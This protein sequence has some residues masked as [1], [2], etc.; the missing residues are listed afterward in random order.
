MVES[1][2]IFVYGCSNVFLERLAG[3][4][5]AWSHGDLEHVSIAFM[6]IGGGLVSINVFLKLKTGQILTASSA[7]FSSSPGGFEIYSIIRYP[8]MLHLHKTRTPRY[9]PSTRPQE[10]II[11]RTT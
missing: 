6:F 9:L 4:G 2:V 10:T 5:G 11:F 1:T 3:A 7:A 8:H